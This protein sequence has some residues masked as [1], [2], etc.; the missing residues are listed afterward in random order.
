MCCCWPFK[1]F[2]YEEPPKKTKKE[3]PKK[4]DK[5]EWVLVPEGAVLH[6]VSKS[7]LQRKH[8][9]LANRPIFIP[10]Q[11]ILQHKPLDYLTSPFVPTLTLHNPSLTNL[12]TVFQLIMNLYTYVATKPALPQPS[13]ASH[14]PHLY[15]YVSSTKRNHN[16]GSNFSNVAHHCH[17][18]CSNTAS[19]LIY[20][21][22]TRQNR[23]HSTFNNLSLTTLP[24]PL[25]P[26]LPLLLPLPPKRSSTPITTGMATPEHKSMP[27][28]SQSLTT[29]AL[30]SR[31][32]SFLITQVHPSS[33]GVASWMEPT[34]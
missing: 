29:P 10:T 34:R 32:S 14:E 18:V 8:L 30:R 28:M 25:L 2:P 22:L 24:N 12:P 3:E 5:T 20:R 9:L 23:A 6:Q 1:S 13:A 31:L 17:L 33:G 7:S 16:Q 21:Q 4:E 27:K 11:S 15:T 19:T 26:Q